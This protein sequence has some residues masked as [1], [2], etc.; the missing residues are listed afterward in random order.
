[1]CSADLTINMDK[2]VFVQDS[3]TYLGYVISAIQVP[4]HDMVRGH[5][6]GSKKI[7]DWSSEAACAFEKCKDS[8]VEA[9]TPSF[10]SHKVPLIFRTDASTTAIGAALEEIDEG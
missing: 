6:K 3:V 9:V 7:I 4:L 8:I 1:M 5:T 10:L 2:T